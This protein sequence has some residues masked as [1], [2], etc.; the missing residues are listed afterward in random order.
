MIKT[1]DASMILEI[2]TQH[3]DQQWFRELK[4]A[5]FL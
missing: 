5:S 1:L 3:A 4:F 2:Y